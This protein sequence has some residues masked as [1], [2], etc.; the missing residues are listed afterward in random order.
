MRGSR[1]CIYEFREDRR[2][3]HST[4]QAVRTTE[5]QSWSMV[6]VDTNIERN[7]P[8]RSPH[9]A[10]SQS[11]HG[12]FRLLPLE[13]RY[14]RLLEQKR[15]RFLYGVAG[16]YLPCMHLAC[17][18]WHR[19][20]DFV[21]LASLLPLT[22]TLIGVVHRPYPNLNPLSSSLIAYLFYSNYSSFY[23]TYSSVVLFQ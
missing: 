4:F 12:R 16:S 13:A 17:L 20:E 14:C 6:S 8:N 21:A 22:L 3:V 7:E 19:P 10:P 1:E 15:P 11:F 23:S 18:G 9:S 5:D 2:G